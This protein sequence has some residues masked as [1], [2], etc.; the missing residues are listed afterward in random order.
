MYADA[1]CSAWS[2]F[3]YQKP[4][5]PVSTRADA[6]PGL[7]ESDSDRYWQPY[8]SS[9]DD[10]TNEEAVGRPG[11]IDITASAQ[12]RL[13]RIVHES[14][15]IYCGSRG[16]VRAQQLLMLYDRYSTW[17]ETLPRDIADLDNEPLPHVL[18][19]Q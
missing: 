2:G 10:D 1:V 16:K 5:A 8:T 15:L 3:I 13:F 6:V 19:L 11:H 4:S 12:A 14:I 17:R 7:F 18:F 9:T